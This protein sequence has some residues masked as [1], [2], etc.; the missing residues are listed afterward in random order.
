MQANP[1][2]VHLRHIAATHTL[3]GPFRAGISFSP[4]PVGF[5]H[6]Y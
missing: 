5:T 1:G 3:S 6:G 4:F 2:G